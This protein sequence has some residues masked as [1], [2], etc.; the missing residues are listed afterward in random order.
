MERLLDGRM[1]NIPIDFR[2][3]FTAAT[4]HSLA[5]IR[6]DA[7]ILRNKTNEGYLMM[8][9]EVEHDL[10]C[11]APAGTVTLGPA[12]PCP[13]LRSADTSRDVRAR[14]RPT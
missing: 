12:Q 1:A 7:A 10:T 11:E 4:T 3:E 5:R 2:S 8:S 13:V 9:L 14:R 6:F